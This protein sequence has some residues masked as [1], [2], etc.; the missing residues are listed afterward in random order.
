MWY[1]AYKWNTYHPAVQDLSLHLLQQ[2]A[3]VTMPERG[4][5]GTIQRYKQVVGDDSQFCRQLARWTYKDLH[6]HTQLKRKMVTH[7]VAWYMLLLQKKSQDI[8]WLYLHTQTQ[9]HDKRT[10]HANSSLTEHRAKGYSYYKKAECCVIYSPSH[11]RGL[12]PKS[13]VLRLN[14]MSAM[15]QLMHATYYAQVDLCQSKKGETGFLL[16]W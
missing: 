8:H 6:W 5:A 1:R 3:T 12:V 4:I 15:V 7:N 14:V 16:P 11:V 2:L 13:M 10:I 9:S